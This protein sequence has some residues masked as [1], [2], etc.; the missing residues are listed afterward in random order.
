V[1]SEEVGG[2]APHGGVRVREESAGA[3]DE[4]RVGGGDDPLQVLE[5]LRDDTAV[6][7]RELR[8]EPR[9]RARG[10]ECF[11]GDAAPAPIGV[12]HNLDGG[13]DAGGAVGLRQR[14]QR[15]TPQRKDAA[16]E[17]RL[18]RQRRGT[19]AQHPQRRLRLDRDA[20]VRV[21][22]ERRHGRREARIAERADGAKRV[23]AHL[24]A[25]VFEQGPQPVHRAAR[26]H[27][28][29]VE[30]RF[31]HAARG[32]GANRGVAICAR[33]RAHRGAAMRP[34][35]G[36]RIQGARA[37]ALVGIIGEGDQLGHRRAGAEA[38]RLEQGRRDDGGRRRARRAGR[39]DLAEGA[40][41]FLSPDFRNRR[42]GFHLRG[43]LIRDGCG[44]H[45]LEQLRQ[46][47]RVLQQT[48]GE[49][50][51]GPDRRARVVERRVEEIDGGGVADAARRKCGLAPHG[52]V[53]VRKRVAD[54][55]G[56]EP[57]GVGRRQQGGELTDE[58]LVGRRRGLLG[59]R[60]TGGR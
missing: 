17:P 42:H 35:P 6:E 39:D 26:I 8:L 9:A 3:H 14:D 5:R 24:G 40:L 13:E 16:R 36:E 34:Q 10:P 30:Q 44:A 4:P 60:R 51:G 33:L 59:R 25:L 56:V 19:A 23:D 2:N 18:Q 31:G 11:G 47:P 58:R 32:D 48:H 49:R 50:R 21:G 53:R 28:R 55:R 43:P 29:A 12:A 20:D 57:A 1:A 15:L 38:P 45:Q 54:R 7:I 22:H 41:P 27:A 46:R 37:R 52:G